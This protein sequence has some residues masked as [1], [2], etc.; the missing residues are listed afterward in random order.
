MFDSCYMDNDFIQASSFSRLKRYLSSPPSGAI[1][2][3]LA[4]CPSE[5][6]C[7]CGLAILIWFNSILAGAGM[8]L[9]LSQNF[10]PKCGGLDV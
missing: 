10:S 1:P 5:Q 4:K 6:H 2:I 8:A 3:V 9:M 7:Y